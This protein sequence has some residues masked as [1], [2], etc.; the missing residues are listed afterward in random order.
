MKSI[1]VLIFAGVFIIITS[2]IC[3]TGRERI[4]EKKIIYNS[5]EEIIDVLNTKTLSAPEKDGGYNSN[6][7]NTDDF[8]ECL[9]RRK[10]ITGTNV[11]FSTLNV[12]IDENYDEQEIINNYLN[13]ARNL[14]NYNLSDKMKAYALSGT[15][16]NRY[17]MTKGNIKLNIVFVDEREGYV[18][19]FIQCDYDYNDKNT[20]G[21]GSIE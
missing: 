8:K 12:T 2:L 3:F 15:Y 1:K 5:P 9:S 18:I 19:D 7:V 20:N 13:N 6:I 17:N 10:R 11:N 16:T 14:N 4:Y 21:L